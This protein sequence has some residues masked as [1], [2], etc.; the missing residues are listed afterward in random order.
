LSVIG[1]EPSNLTVLEAPVPKNKLKLV[2]I[3]I[4]PDEILF[5]NIYS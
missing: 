2:T 5:S 3:P 4:N 1:V